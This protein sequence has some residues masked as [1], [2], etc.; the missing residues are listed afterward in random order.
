M[1]KLPRSF[2]LKLLA[3]T[4]ALF[5]VFNFSLLGDVFVKIIDVLQPVF[6][7]IVLALILNVPMEFLENKVLKKIKKAKIKPVLSIKSPVLI[8]VYNS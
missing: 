3:V 4:I 5:I 6:I 7:G 8:R 1:K 2:L